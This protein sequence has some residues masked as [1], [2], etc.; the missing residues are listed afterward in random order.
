MYEQSEFIYDSLEY[1]LEEIAEKEELEIF[2]FD[3]KG[4]EIFDFLKS[5]STEVVGW[6][7][8]GV[9]VSNEYV[10]EVYDEEIIYIKGILDGMTTEER[11]AFEFEV[12]KLSAVVTSDLA[13]IFNVNINYGKD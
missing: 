12:N 2:Y 7:D 13:R 4:Q 8:S 1:A 6:R 11:D 9:I 10:R 5:A 3:E